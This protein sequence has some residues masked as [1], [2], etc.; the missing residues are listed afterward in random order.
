MSA[1]AP[2]RQESGAVGKH[3]R[4]W[5]LQ[6]RQP[7]TSNNGMKVSAEEGRFREAPTLGSFICCWGKAALPEAGR[8]LRSGRVVLPG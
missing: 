2:P 3:P 7:E 5:K 6:L 4:E 1:Q 8:A